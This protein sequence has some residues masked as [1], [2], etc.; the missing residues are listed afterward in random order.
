VSPDG[1]SLLFCKQP[2]PAQGDIWRL[3]LEEDRTPRPFLVTEAREG[4]PAFSPD[5]RWVS[6]N[7]FESR[8]RQVQVRSYPGGKA[9]YVVAERAS[10]PVWVA[11]GL[12]YLEDF[13][14]EARLMRVPV[15]TRGVSAS[16][17]H[18]PSCSSPTRGSSPGSPTTSPS[19]VT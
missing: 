11:A 14:R 15:D 12:F 6:Y 2:S 13:G 10:D 16:G 4:Q 9:K 18:K 1:R 8:T 5:G 17:R 7:S 3:P 19:E